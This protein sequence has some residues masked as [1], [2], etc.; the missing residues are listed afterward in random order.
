MIGQVCYIMTY[1]LSAVALTSRTNLEVSLRDSMLGLR[2]LAI[3]ALSILAPFSCVRG[4]AFI[5]AS[6][7][8][9]DA[10]GATL[11]QSLASTNLTFNNSSSNSLGVT[12]SDPFRFSIPYHGSLVTI[13]MQN[14]GRPWIPKAAVEELAYR[15]LITLTYAVSLC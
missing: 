1:S 8:F 15:S 13:V 12:P 4:T 9:N 2:G 5:T 11:A 7:Y 6:T 10:A 3:L 14:W